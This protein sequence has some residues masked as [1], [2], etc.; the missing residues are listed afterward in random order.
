MNSNE[1]IKRI[2]KYFKGR[3]EVSTLYIFGSSSKGRQSTE[4]DI[5]IAVLINEAKLK[6]RNYDFLKNDYYTASAD[7]S[8]R[9]VDIV[10]LN[11]APPFLKHQVLKT[12][13]LLF[14]RNRRLRVRFTEKAITEGNR[15]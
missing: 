15:E 7:F 1:D 11:T 5:D 8:L 6:R 4:S 3:D 2:I 10:L 13:R 12:G 9:P 14:D